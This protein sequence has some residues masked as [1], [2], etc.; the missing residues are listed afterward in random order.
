MNI[1]TLKNKCENHIKIALQHLEKSDEILLKI[2]DIE[3]TKNNNDL[4]NYSNVIYNCILTIKNML[5]I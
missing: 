3:K 1:D 5:D 2:I 4:K